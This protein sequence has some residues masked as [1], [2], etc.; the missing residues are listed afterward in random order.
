MYPV[1]TFALVLGVIFLLVGVMGFVPAFVTHPADM[2]GVTVHA[3]H[4]Y[5]LGL[6]PVNLVHNLVHILFGIWG[7]AAYRTGVNGSRLFARSVTVVYAL[8]AVIGLFPNF[9]T[10]FGLCPIHG[11]DTWLHGLIACVS[12]FFGW[13]PVAN[14]PTETHAHTGGGTPLPR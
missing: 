10:L 5:L 6:F 8:L 9:D 4:G 3:N 14:E 13:A 11:N 12:A 1:R 7:I 2:H